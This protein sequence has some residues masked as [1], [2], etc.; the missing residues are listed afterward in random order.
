MLLMKV[1]GERENRADK[2]GHGINHVY[3]V[4]PQHASQ[5]MGNWLHWLARPI[6]PI[7]PFLAG[8]LLP[9]PIE[10]VGHTW[11]T[12]KAIP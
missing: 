5:E 3:R 11:Y 12:K 1:K 9:H 7:I 2:Q 8:I 6:L 10:P 4:R